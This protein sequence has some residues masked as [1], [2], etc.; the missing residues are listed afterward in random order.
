[1]CVG[2]GE[3]GVGGGRMVIGSSLL[4]QACAE[5]TACPWPDAAGSYFIPRVI[6]YPKGHKQELL[7][8]IFFLPSVCFA[9]AD[10]IHSQSLRHAQT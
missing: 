6:Y 8:Q 1:M 9:K 7:V 10:L 4:I 3:S 5:R 2:L